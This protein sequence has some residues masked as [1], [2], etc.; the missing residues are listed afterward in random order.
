MTVDSDPSVHMSAWLSPCEVDLTLRM[1][2]DCCGDERRCVSGRNIEAF[3]VVKDEWISF[4]YSLFCGVV[5]FSFSF[6]GLEIHLW[7]RW[8]TRDRKES[9]GLAGIFTLICQG[10]GSVTGT[11]HSVPWHE[12]GTCVGA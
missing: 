6:K 7:D 12:A 3:L 8:S 9:E 10:R 11:W 5:N 2:K 1:S 4:A